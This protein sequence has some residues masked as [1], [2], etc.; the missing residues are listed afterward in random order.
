MNTKSV[1]VWLIAL[2]MVMISAFALVFITGAKVAKA[3]TVFGFE[4]GAYVKLADDGG[5]RFRLQMDE[6]T[7][8]EIKTDDNKMLYFYVASAARMASVFTGEDAAALYDTNN[9]WRVEAAK[10]KIYQGRDENGNLDGYYYANILLDI[11]ALGDSDAAK[12]AY[13]TTDFVAMA[14]V[15]DQEANDGEGGYTNTAKSPSRSLQYTASAGALRG[16]YYSQVADTYEWLGSSEDYSII[17]SD[18]KDYAALKTALK[19]KIGLFFSLDV[20]DE[21][22][23]LEQY[24]IG[25][26][27]MAKAGNNGKSDVYFQS[28]TGLSTDLPVGTAVTVDMDVYV[29]GT[30]NDSYGVYCVDSVWSTAGGESNAKTNIKSDIV[31]GDSGWHHV[32]FTA[33]VRNFSA[34]R[35][36]Q[37]YSIADTSAFGNAVYLLSVNKSADSFKFKNVVITEE[38]RTM[39]SGGANTTGNGFYQSMTGLTTDLD[40]GTVVTVDMDVKV[41]GT[42]NEYS[43]IYCVD[44]VYANANAGGAINGKTDLTSTIVTGDS[45]WHHVTFFATVRNFTELRYNTAQYNTANTSEYGNA[46]YI[47]TQNKSA[48]AFDYKNVVVSQI[49]TLKS[50]GANTTGNGFY[51]SM[52]GLTTDLDVGT[53]VTVDMDVY[54]TGTF[55]QYSGIYWVNDVYTVSGGESDKS[56]TNITSTIVTGESGW[57]HVTFTATVRNFKCLRYNSGQY[58]I[59]DTSEYG[60]AVYIITQNKSAAAFNYKNVVIAEV[61]TMTSGGANTKNNGFYQ[62]MTGLT[63]DLDVGTTV[64]VDMDVYITGSFNEYSSIYCV[65]EVWTVSGGERKTSTNITSVIVTGEEGW[66]HVTFTAT[67]RNFPVLRLN[68]NYTVTDTSAFGNAVYLLTENN[69]SAAFNYKNVVISKFNTLKSGGANTTGNGFYQS[70]TGLTTDLDVGTFVTVDMD[71]YVTGTFDQYSNIYC[72]DTVYANAGGAINGK[73]NLTST[74]VTGD[75]DWHHVTFTATV[76]NFTELRYNTAQYN[77]EN[78]SEYGNAVYIITQN[79]SAAAFNY[80][81]V[82]I[83][84]E[85]NTMIP[86][87]N[88]GAYYQSITGISTDYNAGTDV[89]VEMDVYVTGTFDDTN[90]N[91][92]W[93]DSVWSNNLW[94]AATKVISNA[95]ASAI[96]GAWTHIVFTARVRNFSSLGISSAVDTSAYGNAVY[97]VSRQKTADCLIYKNVTITGGIDRYNVVVSDSEY[98]NDE[99]PI[100]YAANL[101]EDSISKAGGEVDIIFDS[102]PQGDYEIILGATN[103]RTSGEYDAESYAI[104]NYGD[105]LHIDAA[106]SRGIIYGAYRW[107][108]S[109]GFGF[110][111]EDVTT[112]PSFDD[113]KV[114][115]ID[116]SYSPTFDYREVVYKGAF[117]VDWA[118]SAGINGDIEKSAISNAQYGGYVGYVNGAANVHTSIGSPH[119]VNRAHITSDSD[120]FAKDENGDYYATTVD[121]YKNTQICL[122]SEGALSVAKTYIIYWLQANYNAQTTVRVMASIMDN[123]NYCK[124]DGCMAKYDA[125]GTTGAWLMWVNEL[126]DHVKTNGYP[127]VYIE[128]LAYWWTKQL[129][130]GDVKP[131]DNVIVRFCTNFGG[132]INDRENSSKLDSEKTL[133]QGWQDI[134]DNVYVYYYAIDYNNY[135]EIFPNFDDIYYNFNYMYSIGVKGVYCEGALKNNGEFGELRSFLLAKMMQNPSMT[136]AEY[137]NLMTEFCNEY[138]GAAGSYVLSYIDAV[139][140]AMT[141]DIWTTDKSTNAGKYN[142]VSNSINFTAELKSSAE[143]YWN[144]A[145]SAVAEDATSLYRVQK[146]RLH[147]TYAMLCNYE[148]DYTSSEYNAATLAL[149]T[150]MHNMSVRYVHSVAT[151][152]KNTSGYFTH[153]QG[154][155]PVNWKYQPASGWADQE[156]LG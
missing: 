7:A 71:V 81:N 19:K 107:L 128:T 30:F 45:D 66:H 63:T 113:I 90:C 3:E 89:T 1:K 105:T 148:S 78:T 42:F 56:R 24:G 55:D 91:V 68:A 83:T 114:T 141:G 112:V 26:K 152:G 47:I 80:K 9:A 145:E 27:T 116:V 6:E 106:D 127:D 37:S 70:M 69:S 138:Y 52:T 153:Y 87:G 86:G 146:S 36:D 131:A 14:T 82:V 13:R 85:Y 61:K 73:T 142:S 140:N 31:T 115:D 132:C 93:V 59:T 103:R 67:V 39:K 8:T 150:A 50:G 43:Y 97:L 109:V 35:Y 53:V 41:T 149:A 4:S 65:D 156:N 118:V 17:A 136:Y 58:N 32:T 125:Y 72:V 33:T 94:N 76:R 108:E 144:A 84:A 155:N 147:W 154:V 25:T 12:L 2:L 48:A 44:T 129:P 60:N 5:L 51:Q 110:Y 101:L 18:A 11:N 88:S 57:H 40:V 16:G 134:C 54:V 95:E 151:I 120:Y 29:T 98:G 75:S 21:D 20:I 139:K 137:R 22:G 102:D 119:L 104:K 135:M 117:D 62:S 124:C 46:V 10:N 77:T 74:I 79:K 96:K 23:V 122:S 123:N 49:N 99:S 121:D 28:V 130:Q 15:Y 64:T 92:W 133:L 38:Y 143:G 34:L 111:E 100:I 126:A